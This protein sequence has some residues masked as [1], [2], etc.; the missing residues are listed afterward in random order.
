MSTKYLANEIRSFVEEFSLGRTVLC[1][2]EIWERK[3]LR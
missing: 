1:Y 2:W 3:S